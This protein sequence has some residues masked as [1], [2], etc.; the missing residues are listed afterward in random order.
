[1][2]LYCSIDAETVSKTSEIW[3]SKSFL[4]SAI[5]F[6]IFLVSELLKFSPELNLVFD[7]LYC[8]SY[9]L[10]AGLVLFDLLASKYAE[11][12]TLADL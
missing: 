10:G 12:N 8:K 11:N 2:V 4:A 3:S 9:R 5:F 6:F 7:I 1:M